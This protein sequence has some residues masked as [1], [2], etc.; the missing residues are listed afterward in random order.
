MATF[1][2]SLPSSP[3]L[4]P[5]T[6]ELVNKAG[7]STATFTGKQK[8]ARTVGQFW[9]YELTMPE[10]RQ[11]D[12]GK[13]TSF[14]L[15]L[16]GRK[17][18]FLAGDPMSAQVLGNVDTSNTIQVLRV[19]DNFNVQIDGLTANTSSVLNPGDYIQFEDTDELKLVTQT[20]DSNDNGVAQVGFEPALHTHPSTDTNVTIQNAKGEFRLDS[21]SVEW[22]ESPVGSQ[23]SFSA[24]ETF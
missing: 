8:V 7:V 11:E 20:V 21:D 3:A 14:L 24:V 12:H 6:L 16:Q 13:W 19:I 17:E 23:L 10:I 1:P 2:I 4:G 5:V 9:V 22:S 15:Q 18:T